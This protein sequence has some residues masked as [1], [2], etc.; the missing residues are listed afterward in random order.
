MMVDGFGSKGY[1]DGSQEVGGD[2]TDWNWMVDGFG[3]KGYGDGSQE[4][5]GDETDWNGL[6]RAL[7]DV[8]LPAQ[9]S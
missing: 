7:R 4:V 3:S 9:Q 5:G 1:G 2:E 8:G 6:E